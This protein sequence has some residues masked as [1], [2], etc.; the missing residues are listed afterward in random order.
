MFFWMLIWVR[1]RTQPLV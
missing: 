1:L